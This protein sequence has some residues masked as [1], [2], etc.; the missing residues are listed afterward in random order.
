MFYRGCPEGMRTTLEK[1]FCLLLTPHFFSYYDDLCFRTKK[2][3]TAIIIRR[4][5][6][7]DVKKLEKKTQAYKGIKTITVTKA[8]AAAAAAT[9]AATARAAAPVP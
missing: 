1:T 3:L 8:A 4:K 5:C 7:V 2:H 9:A 6:H